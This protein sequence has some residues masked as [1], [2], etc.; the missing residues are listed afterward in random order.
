M[1]EEDDGSAGL[2]KL[3]GDS[4]DGGEE[5]EH[6]HPG[7]RRSGAHGSARPVSEK[8]LAQKAQEVESE[9][10]TNLERQK[11][12]EGRFRELKARL[13]SKAGDENHEINKFLGTAK[14]TGQQELDEEWGFD[15]SDYLT[16]GAEV[17]AD[18]GVAAVQQ[19]IEFA[20]HDQSLMDYFH[21]QSGSIDSLSAQVS[22]FSNLIGNAEEKEE[23]RVSELEAELESAEQEYENRVDDIES[24][25]ESSVSGLKD[26]ISNMSSGDVEDTSYEDTNEMWEGEWDD[27]VSEAREEKDEAESEYEQRQEEVQAEI[28]EARQDFREQRETLRES[29]QEAV[30]ERAERLDELEEV[31]AEFSNDV[32]EYVEEQTAGLKDLM[33]TMRSLENMRED[34]SEDSVEAAFD[35]SAELNQDQRGISA[36]ISEAAGS[37]A[38][39]AFQRI[40]Y[41]EDAVSDYV[42]AADAI[43]EELD[44]QDQRVGTRVDE[45]TGVYDDLLLDSL[46]ETGEYGIEGLRRRVMDHVGNAAEEEYDAVDEFRE[47][48]ESMARAP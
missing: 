28:S 33:I 38:Y 21:S 22:Q 31:H 32:I 48:V 42:T 6:K 9:F 12:R 10:S 5:V 2:S 8:E 40:E 29:K 23:A 3:F 41:L 16:N 46:D 17:E 19:P 26:Q 7:R 15:S 47:H 24:E 20:E 36:D 30:S 45:I 44:N 27:I 4:L 13:E 43:T 1:T 39:R 14:K 25:K 37:L 34:Y 11:Q 18:G 35:G